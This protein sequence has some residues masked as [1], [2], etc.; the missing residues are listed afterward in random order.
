[1]RRALPLA[2]AALLAAPLVPRASGAETATEAPSKVSF[3]VLVKDKKGLPVPDLKPEEL[4]VIENGS[5]RPVETVRFVPPGAV[6]AEGSADPGQLVSLVFDGLGVEQQK[7]AKKAVEDLLA[8]DLGPNTWIGVF[9]IGLQLW[10]VQPFTRDL[11]LVRQGVEKAA[12]NLDAT[13]AAPEQAARQ[14]VAASMADLAAGKAKDPAAVSRAEVLGKIMRH[15]DRLLRQQQQG[16]PLYLLMA[17]AKGQASAPGR[18]SVLYYTGGLTV[19]SQIDDVYR[20]TISEAS[21]AGVS[22]YAVDVGGLGTS[23]EAQSARDSIQDVARVS[24]EAA[25]DTSGAV[26]LDEVQLSDKAVDSTRGNWKQPLKE[27]SESTGGFATLDTND[28]KKPMERLAT[29]LGGHYEVAYAPASAAWDGASRK[30]EFKTTRGGAKVQGPTTYIATP[31]DDSGP[32]L[33]YELPLLEALKSPEGRKDLP[34]TSGVFR[35]GPH[36]EGRD[37]VLVAEIPMSSLKFTEDAKAKLYKLHFALLA[38]V[39]DRE[40]K[41]VERVS[42]DYPFQGPLDKLPQLRQGNVVFKRR[43]VV[44]PGS[45]TIELVAQDR[46]GAATSVVRAALEVPA[47]DRLAVSSVVIVRRMEQAPPLKAGAPEDP[48]RGE[49]MRIVP[50]LDDPISKATTSKMPVYLIVYP[51]PDGGA[52][53]MTIEF[54]SGGKAEGRSSVALP[55]P[56]PDGRIRFLAPIP[57]DRFGPG[58]HEL[59]VS[60]RQG[61]AQAEDRVAFTLVP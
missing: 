48:L 25:G 15:G 14:A 17:V 24:R 7:L 28:Y 36:P 46:D 4:A 3:K 1:M 26:S 54:S 21:R 42:Q 5:R 43:L 2:L 52:P 53:Q 31:P 34:I 8:R 50:S 29:D 60:V 39:K 59:R 51:A 45:Y 55:A 40:G 27:L 58:R 22:F 16:S 47:A 32:I 20:A 49:A 44:P 37:H 19:P 57:V 61:T 41:V 11:A 30:I 12:S 56:D 13:L 6:P 35:F 10:T 38:V 33:A 23:S 18:K 9:R